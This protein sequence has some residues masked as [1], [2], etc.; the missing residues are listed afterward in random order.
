[1]YKRQVKTGAVVKRACIVDEAPT[2]AR[3][4]GFDMPDVD[5][6]VLTEILR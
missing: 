3:M 4:L 1:M 2:M 6:R 5:G